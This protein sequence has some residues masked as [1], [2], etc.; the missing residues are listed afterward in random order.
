MTF[1]P[2]AL[3]DALT[4][5]FHT[6]PHQAVWALRALLAGLAVY[7][8]AVEP[9]YTTRPLLFMSAAWGLVVSL[10]F[11]F[12]PTR[13]PRTLKAA[14]FGTLLAFALHVMGHAFGWYATFRGYDTLLHFAVP[15]VCVLILYALSQAVGWIWDWR[16]VKPVE[17]GVYLFAMSITLGVLWEIVEFGMDRI[18]G[19]REQDGL[20][21]TMV[22]LIMDVLGSLVGSILVALATAYGRRHGHEKVSEAPKRPI[23]MRAP[24]GA[25]KE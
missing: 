8:L 7:S 15:I 6:L 9:T 13:R 20:T 1:R 12:I 4:P 19:T 21:D 17:V 16:L 5:E 14:E 10:G 22:D 2:R 23:P 18:F 25:S 11:A 24:R 3:R